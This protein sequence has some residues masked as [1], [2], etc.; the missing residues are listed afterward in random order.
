MKFDV[1]IIS[2]APWASGCQI[3]TYGLQE[4]PEISR[5]LK[6]K[7]IQ[8]FWHPAASLVSL[9]CHDPFNAMWPLGMFAIENIKF[10]IRSPST[11]FATPPALEGKHVLKMSQSSI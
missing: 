9:L 1:L 10:H 8:T 11:G 6:S 4:S 3:I 5:K 2:R 7:N